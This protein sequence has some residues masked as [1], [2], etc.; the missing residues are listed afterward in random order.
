ML[1]CQRGRRNVHLVGEGLR[2]DGRV[3]LLLLLHH[4][5]HVL[6]RGVVDHDDGRVH[7]RRGHVDL[8]VLKEVDLLWWLLRRDDLLLLLLLFMVLFVRM[9]VDKCFAMLLLLLQ[10]DELRFD[11]NRDLFGNHFLDRFGFRNNG[12]DRS[13]S[14]DNLGRHLLLLFTVGGRVGFGGLLS[15]S[16]FSSGLLFLFRA[17]SLEISAGLDRV[18]KALQILEIRFPDFLRRLAFD[19]GDQLVGRVSDQ[20][21]VLVV[22]EFSGRDGLGEVV[23]VAELFFGQFD[24]AVVAVAE[25]GFDLGLG[26]QRQEILN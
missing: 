12:G 23:D 6:G 1:H 7:V 10:L 24:G 9:G 4:G 20:L 2:G 19:Q 5:Q 13:R 14:F 3:G 25:V 21:V 18:E 17:F 16:V 8:R 15:L 22:R 26:H 11:L